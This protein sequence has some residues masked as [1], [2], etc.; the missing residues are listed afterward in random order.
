MSSSVSKW[1]FSSN[2]SPA[3]LEKTVS[4]KEDKGSF[5]DEH[6]F[7]SVESL[8]IRF[9]SLEDEV[10]NTLCM[11]VSNGVR[12]GVA[13]STSG[14]PDALSTSSLLLPARDSANLVTA[15]EQ[16]LD[17]L[18]TPIPQRPVE[19]TFIVS[20][21]S[22]GFRTE[23]TILGNTLELRRSWNP[24]QAK[25]FVDKLTAAG[26]VINKDLTINRWE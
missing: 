25:E 12:V 7:S 3:T 17:H 2:T 11:T 13:R 6:L 14:K 10:Q 5:S 24:S 18:T 23:I 9:L 4:V 15:I 19:K 16:T 20:P 1:A 26:K 21:P 8:R 22:R